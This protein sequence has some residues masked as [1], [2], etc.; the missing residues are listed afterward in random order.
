MNEQKLNKPK[1]LIL[2]LAYF[3]FIGGAEVAVAEIT[4]R[5]G[6]EPGE[7]EF[8]LITCNLD[9]QQRDE[10]QIG[11][12][13]IY[14]V[15]KGKVGKHLFHF[16]G[17]KKAKALHLKN[18][19]DIIWSM[20]ANRAGFA[21]LFFKKKFPKVK[22]LLTLQE[23]DS[24]FNI[25]KKTWYI[26]PFYKA[27][28]RSANYI[29]AISNF[30]A[31][32]ALKYGYQGPIEMV[33][34]GVDLEKFNYLKKDLIKN[35][36]IILT[37]SRLVE[38]NGVADLIKALYILVTNYSLNVIKIIIIGTGPL[39]NDLK[40]L[41]QDL[42][43]ANKINFL[44]LIPYEDVQ[45]YYA[46]ADVFVR[47]SLTEGLGN[48]FLQAMA[49]EIPVIATPV[50]GIPDFL[51]D[52]ETGWFCEVKNPKSIAEKINY[53]LDEKNKNEVDGVVGK[54][55][56]MVEEKYS[57]KKIADKMGKIFKELC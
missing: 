31:K 4:K 14:R 29:Q 54:A 5:L 10:E 52:G 6:G 8:D 28:Y 16:L 15:G 17:Y 47:P 45:K 22:F 32:R 21:A 20:M 57:W 1:I 13:K 7:F 18:N 37:D 53:I 35:E 40:K 25:W 11:N 48:V 2:S 50:G 49:A 23:G 26:R 19:Y 9:G 44:G 33:P 34:N 36:K 27:I 30:L 39:E 46:L 38:K 56:K 55:R 3:P 24:V 12:V 43:V 51:K 42:G 41:A